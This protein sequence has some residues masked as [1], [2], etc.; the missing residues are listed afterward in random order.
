[1]KQVLTDKEANDMFITLC[2]QLAQ[3]KG[4]EDCA[5]YYLNGNAE[6]YFQSIYRIRRAVLN[7]AIWR[8]DRLK[9]QPGYGETI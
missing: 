9:K 1:M 2:E 6:E 4:Y 3:E 8:R 5:E 7:G